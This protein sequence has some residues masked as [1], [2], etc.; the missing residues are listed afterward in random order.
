MPLIFVIENIYNVADNQKTAIGVFLD[1]AK[2]FVTVDYKVL[3][4]YN[5]IYVRNC[6]YVLGV[7]EHSG[8]RGVTL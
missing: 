6:Y 8:R 5:N 1:L 2:A 3:I 4:E 7:L